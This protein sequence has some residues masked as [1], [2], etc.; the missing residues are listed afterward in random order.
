MAIA[1]GNL[2]QIVE[3]QR[4]A[5]QVLL[6][7]YFYQITNLVGIPTYLQVATAFVNHLWT[8]DRQPLTSNWLSYEVCEIRNMT[9]MIDVFEHEVNQL[10]TSTTT[11]PL[12]PNVN[13][14]VKLVRGTLLTRNGYKRYAGIPEGDQANGV[15]VPARLTAWQTFADKVAA[16]TNFSDAGEEW[17]LIPVIVGTDDDGK[18]DYS[19]MNPIEGAVMSTRLGTQNTRKIKAS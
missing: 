11:D 15:L 17:S 13:T 14:T 2:L 6:N 5:N 8:G 4:Q 16:I 1:E 18:R 10:G 19:I 7:V 3:K 9:N 12:P